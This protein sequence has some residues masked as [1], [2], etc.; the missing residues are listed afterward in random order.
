MD[1]AKD[2]PASWKT[3]EALGGTFIRE[4]FDEENVHCF[5]K[6]YEIKVNESIKKHSAIYEPNL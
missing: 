3:M 4:Y 5:V 6:D 1:A 2:N